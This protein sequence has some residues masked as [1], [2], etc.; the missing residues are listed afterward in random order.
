MI[1]GKY[2]DILSEYKIVRKSVK[3][4]DSGGCFIYALIN[5]GEI[6]YVGQTKDV[7][8]RLYS[9]ANDKE[10]EFDSYYVEAVNPDC[11]DEIETFLIFV[12]SPKYNISKNE[13]SKRKMHTPLT[14]K[15][16][17]RRLIENK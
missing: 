12:N 9:H 7:E 4:T 17:L 6:V 5:K 1:G 14:H 2:D 8:K 11:V 13:N 3:K 16:I 10:K 15:E